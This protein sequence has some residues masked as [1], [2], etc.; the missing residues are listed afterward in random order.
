[1]VAVTSPPKSKQIESILSD[2]YQQLEIY[3]YILEARKPTLAE[4]CAQLPK[5]LPS[6][7]RRKRRRGTLDESQR[8]YPKNW[9]IIARQIKEERNYLCQVCSLQC[10]RPEDDKSHLTL[11]EIGQLTA[12]CHHIDGNGFNNCPENLLVVCST[13]HLF[14]HRGRR[15]NPPKGQGSLFNLID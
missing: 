12:N 14:I 13:H 11:S 15:R 5:S 8:K 4:L 6:K 9:K 1:M 10:L 3:Q 7:S 2:R